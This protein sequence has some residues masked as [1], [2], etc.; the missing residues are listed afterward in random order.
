MEARFIN[1]LKNKQNNLKENIL[2]K[3]LK[4]PDVLYKKAKINYNKTSKKK[5]S[6]RKIKINEEN[7]ENFNTNIRYISNYD[8]SLHIQ[9]NENFLVNKDMKYKN[10]VENKITY[11]TA[12]YKLLKKKK[13]YNTHLGFSKIIEKNENQENFSPEKKKKALKKIRKSN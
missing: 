13:V 4:D 6:N 11:E 5:D 2:S 3:G 12:F 10:I 9:K 1:E 7:K 8:K